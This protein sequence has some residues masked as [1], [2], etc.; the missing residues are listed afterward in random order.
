M[1]L[2]LISFS[3]RFLLSPTP[4]IYF[5]PMA[6]SVSSP[7]CCRRALVALQGLLP[8]RFLHL[9]SVERIESSLPEMNSLYSFFPS[10]IAW[11][12]LSF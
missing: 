12:Y 4:F 5:L 11:F 8:D 9:G 6:G 10:P 1:L 3:A 2:F 7:R